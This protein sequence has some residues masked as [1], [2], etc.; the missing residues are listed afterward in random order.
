METVDSDGVIRDAAGAPVD[1][2]EGGAIARAERDFRGIPPMTVLMG[3]VVVIML[4][5]FLGWYLFHARTSFRPAAASTTPGT[6]TTLAQRDAI[7]EDQARQA[8]LGL[9]ATG[10]PNAVAMGPN[11]TT[12]VSNPL[13]PA[14]QQ[15]PVGM[16]AADAQRLGVPLQ[17]GSSGQH[18][19]DPRVALA[20]ASRRAPIMGF[21]GGM[22]G[23]R[24]AAAGQQEQGQAGP[25]QAL[26]ALT[27]EPGASGEGQLA[28]QPASP[29]APLPPG[30]SGASPTQD[31]LSSQLG[32]HVIES[33]RATVVANRSFLLSAGTLV[34]CTLQT[35]INSTQAGYVSCVI[36]HDVYSEDGRVVI[37]DKGT[38]VLGQYSGGINQ[39][40]ARLF[41]LW[42][43]ALT[44]RGVAIDLGSP[45]ADDLGRAG[46]A[47]GVDTMFWQRF[48]G[49]LM[50]SVLQDLGDI[51]SSR[52]ANRGSQ[53]TQV[54]ADTAST[55][56][57][58]TINIQPIL[59]K[60]QGDQVAIFVAKDFDFSS[61][62]DVRVRR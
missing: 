20:Q 51:A 28:G 23:L 10:A 41:V 47:G 22:N 14:G 45:A 55:A 48:G 43:R 59:K 37:L 5:L 39:G 9:P 31:G 12:M 50:L 27:G 32:H 29:A 60:N 2:V 18:T 24:Q 1:R 17:N 54:P 4:G 3:A 15:L 58:G 46:M 38:K 19:V 11:G 42:T 44:P 7:T 61:V 56:L 35:A 34:P 49:A 52:F 21:S 33:A 62:Y 6:A 26:A 36:G 40:Q 8:L 16:S 13:G 25:G 30:G 57:R 53:T